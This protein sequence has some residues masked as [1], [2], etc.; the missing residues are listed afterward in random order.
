MLICD[1]DLQP[2]WWVLQIDERLGDQIEPVIGLFNCRML[3]EHNDLARSGFREIDVQVITRPDMEGRLLPMIK[4][5][6]GYARDSGKMGEEEIDGVLSTLD[7]A[8]AEKTYLALAPQ[9]VV[10]GS[11]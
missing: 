1:V 9:F 6:A 11:R 8:L 2:V 4:N 3:R 10:T 5:M 7:R